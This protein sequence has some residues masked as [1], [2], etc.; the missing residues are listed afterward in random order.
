MISR[1][2]RLAGGLPGLLVGEPLRVEIEQR[3]R[4]D[5]PPTGRGSGH[6]VD[7]PTSAR[8]AIDASSHEDVVESAIAMGSDTDTTACAAGG[9]AGLRDGVDAIPRRWRD[10]LRGRSILDPTLS[11]L[12]A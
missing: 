12:L 10:E 8:L 4:P 3:V 9:I 11:A 2:D 5:E 6:V 1:T 7:C